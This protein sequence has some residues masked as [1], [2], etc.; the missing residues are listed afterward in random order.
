MKY[1]IATIL[2]AGAG[3]LLL[4]AGVLAQETDQVSSAIADP[5]KPTERR[6]EISV[7]YRYDRFD[8]TFSPWHSTSVA[9]SRQTPV[10]TVIG[11]VNHAR[12]FDR[13]GAQVELDAYPKFAKNT[14][15]YVNLGYAPSALFPEWR[16]GAEL[17]RSLPG[18]WES[19][20]GLRWLRFESRD[21]RIYTGSVGRYFGNYWISARPFVTPTDSATSVTTTVT[22]R[23]YFRD[24]DNYLGVMVGYGRSPADIVS[25]QHLSYEQRVKLAAEG[26][27]AVHTDLRLTWRLSYDREELSRGRPN[28]QWGLKI[29][30][31]R[32][33]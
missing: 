19:S 21:V 6:S 32:D 23:R 9:L 33:F 11:R 28:N 18:S 10:G 25:E 5:R 12:R 15:G 13:S 2:V 14:Y 7:D 17:H 30:F 8:R 31:E 22:A 20:V 1:L 16:A 26:K 27:R 3:F 29:G 24:G 4:P